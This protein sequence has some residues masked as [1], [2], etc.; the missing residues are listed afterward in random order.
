[1]TLRDLREHLYDIV[2]TYFGGAEVMWSENNSV[3]PPLPFVMLKTGSATPTAM[4]CA[5]HVNGAVRN[6]YPTRTILEVT[7]YTRGACVDDSDGVEGDRINTA[8]SDLLDF[9]SFI[10][11]PY[12]SDMT[13]G[14]DI[15]V[16][17]MG[18]V[19]DVTAL[20][21]DTSHEYRA[22]V[23]LTV[24]FIY[25]SAGAA[26]VIP[27]WTPNPSGGGTEELAA[28]E[29]GYFEKVVFKEDFDK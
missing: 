9:V 13:E 16:K 17:P 4:P 7:L 19:R 3:R 25:I 2:A 5:Q 23:E 26:G 22:M 14:L 10:H 24:D 11:S 8:A 21:N 1:M 29:T 6:D 15:T 12:V 28:M 27:I 18:P 20:L